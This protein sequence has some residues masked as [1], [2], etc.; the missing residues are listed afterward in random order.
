MA[1]IDE[2]DDLFTLEGLSKKELD[3]KLNCFTQYVNDLNEARKALKEIDKSIGK[4]LDVDSGYYKRGFISSL[5]KLYAKYVD[6][7]NKIKI[8]I[9]KE[10]KNDR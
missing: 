3:N 5:D 2:N 10:V 9:K 8:A 1:L 6:R 7:C 4:I